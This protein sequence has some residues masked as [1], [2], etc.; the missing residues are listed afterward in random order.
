MTNIEITKTDYNKYMESIAAG[1]KIS[2]ELFDA[3]FAFAKVKKIKRPSED[4]IAAPEDIIEV[5]ETK[6]PRGPKVK[7]KC[8]VTAAEDPK[9]AEG[10]TCDAWSRS[11]G[12]CAKHYSRLVYRAKPENMEKA[13]QASKNY[14]DKMRK[15]KEA[16]KAAE[17]EVAE[18]A[19]AE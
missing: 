17:V 2:Q 10:E 9:M 8:S 5:K 19:A 4:A 18:T 1:E 14:A 3:L 16:K 13:R 11:D 12:M 6:A 15:L 7:V